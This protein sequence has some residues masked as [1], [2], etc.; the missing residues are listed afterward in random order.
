MRNPNVE[1]I[2]PEL[3]LVNVFPYFVQEKPSTQLYI[4]LADLILEHVFYHPC[5]NLDDLSDTDKS[6]VDTMLGG[7]TPQQHLISILLGVIQSAIK[8]HHECI[9]LCLSHTD[10][11]A[12][13]A[14]LGQNELKEVNP[15]M[16]VRG[17]S[18]FVSDFYKDAFDV[19]CQIVKRLRSSGYDIELVIPFVRTL[20][21]GACIID[22]LAEKGLP[23]GLDKFKVH[24][25]C[26][27]P[28]SVLL[29]DKLLHYFDGVVV[30]LDSLGEFTF[31]IDRTNE[32]LSGQ[33]DLQNEAL[34]ILIERVIAETNKVN[35]PC[36]IKM[37]ALKPYPKLQSLFV[38]SKGLKIAISE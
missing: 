17:V 33:L 9:K 19:E 3:D 31:A 27:M 36:L 24:F 12:F 22:K 4:S 29:V 34:I 25:S 32:Q 21:D 1:E 14:L 15:A 38:E 20:S 7:Q 30:N 2:H 10:S 5:I 28:S 26:D 18:R 23:R 13:S 16:G 6:T 11:Y 8:P 35:K 37:A